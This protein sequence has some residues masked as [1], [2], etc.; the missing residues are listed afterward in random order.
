MPSAK[1]KEFLSN[2]SPLIPSPCPRRGLGRG[3][4]P[5]C[6]NQLPLRQRFLGLNSLPANCDRTTSPLPRIETVEKRQLRVLLRAWLRLVPRPLS[7]RERVGQ[8]VQTDLLKSPRIM[9]LLLRQCI[10]VS[11]G[12][13]QTHTPTLSPSTRLR[14]RSGQALVRE[15]ASGR[16]SLAIS[17]LQFHAA[18]SS[19]TVSIQGEGFYTLS[20][21]LPWERAG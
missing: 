18:S 1:T 19:S 8:R 5:L 3:P 4:T 21:I 12:G 6:E 9:I 14:L 15:R 2:P 20:H 17:R 10:C 11:G 13:P 7:L 16:S